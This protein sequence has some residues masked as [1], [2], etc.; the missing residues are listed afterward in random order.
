MQLFTQPQESY[1]RDLD[2]VKHYLHD[3]ASYLSIKK[4]LPY[5]E[6]YEK[7]KAAISPG[8]T[9]EFKDPRVLYLAKETEGNRD[10]YTGTVSGYL[11][12]VSERNCI[13]SPTMAVYF[14]PAEKRSLLAE[15]ILLN[16]AKRKDVKKKMFL[17]DMAG[18]K[19]GKTFFNILQTTYK[20]KNNSLSGAHA[21]ASTPLYNKSSHSTL[22][23][24]CR[25]ASGTA[26]ASNERFITGNRHYYNL[27]IT[28]SNIIS[29]VSNSDYVK[30]QRAMDE[31]NLHYPSVEETLA[32]IKRSTDLYWRADDKFAHVAE[33]VSRLSPIQRAAF[34]YMGDLWNLKEFNPA[35]MREMLTRL[36]TKR[37]EPVEDPVA[38]IKALDDDQFAL[39]GLYCGSIL[40]GSTIWD[41][42]KEDGERLQKVASI[43]KGVMD[44]IASYAT[45]YAAFM[46]TDNVPASL[47]DFPS[48]VR[49]TAVVSDTDS[50]IFTVQDWA[51]W[52][53]GQLDF[54]ETSNDIASIVVYFSSQLVK[55]YLAVISGNMGIVT[56]KI[57]KVSMKNEYMFPVFA[58]TPRAKH[59]FAYMSA[60]EGNV[61]TEPELEVKGVTLKNSKVPDEIMNGATQLIRDIMDTIL[62]GEQID[63][64][65]ILKDVA[66]RE[67]E[68]QNSILNGETRYLTTAQV[69]APEFYTKPESS[70]YA[71]YELWEQVFADKYGHSDPPPFF[72]IKAS[73]AAN[74]KTGFNGWIEGIEDKDLA[75]RLKTWAARYDKTS[76][77]TIMLPANIV[78]S[79]GVPP[80]ITRII[81]V[82][83]IIYNTMEA[84]YLVLESLGYYI[85][86]DDRISN[87]IS[88]RH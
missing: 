54:T 34:C 30:I 75:E 20:V 59:Y 15:Y 62:R 25:S 87:L 72:A 57:H 74:N 16:L 42:V 81:D 64:Q 41:V 18:D 17:A 1:G 55:H 85:N 2:M 47:A 13:M 45:Y 79:S 50:T 7:V 39:V 31:F 51:I 36:I 83:K 32:T 26:N 86:V 44:A 67:R 69:K 24:V 76:M 29:I 58:L 78:M 28:L 48:S 77:T 63:L 23:S 60:R 73:V 80:E 56:E 43:A 27:D 8:G 66:D 38:V 35:F 9:H 49:R 3:A 82:R 46:V 19:A 84:Y 33:L 52:Y 88:D 21:S 12:T 61:Y 37:T 65:Q 53:R 68:I 71:Y 14:N 6:C 5:E 10:V 11:R 40:N 22:T 4:G 70:P